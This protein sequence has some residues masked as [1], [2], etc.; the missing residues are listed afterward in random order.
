MLIGVNLQ[1]LPNNRWAPEEE[2]IA[3]LE[4]ESLR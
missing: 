2:L 1:E 4:A 3:V